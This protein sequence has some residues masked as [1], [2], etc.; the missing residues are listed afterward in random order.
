[1]LFGDNVGYVIRGC[2]EENPR[3]MRACVLSDKIDVNN[4]HMRV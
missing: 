3:E 1:M 2:H 4:K